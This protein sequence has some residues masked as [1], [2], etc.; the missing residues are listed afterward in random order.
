MSTTVTLRASVA[1][2]VISTIDSSSVFSIISMVWRP[3]VALGE[4]IARLV[5]DHQN[6]AAA[7]HFGGVVQATPAWPVCAT[8]AQ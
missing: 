4:N 7:Q 3:L 8:A 5:I 2:L 6:L 1:L